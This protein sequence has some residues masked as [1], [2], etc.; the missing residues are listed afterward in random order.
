[1]LCVTA[2]VPRKRV[3]GKLPVLTSSTR[4][5]RE[6]ATSQAAS[7]VETSQPIPGRACMLSAFDVEIWLHTIHVLSDAK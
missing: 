7:E 6:N 3:I 2:E 1:M 5:V 4:E